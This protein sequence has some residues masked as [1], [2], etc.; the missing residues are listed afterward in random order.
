MPPAIKLLRPKQWIKNFF[1]FAPLMFSQHMFDAGSVI[2][3]VK[4]TAGLSNA[5]LLFLP[6]AALREIPIRVLN[7]DTAEHLAGETRVI[8]LSGYSLEGTIN[9][10]AV[11]FKDGCDDRANYGAKVRI[12]L[13]VRFRERSFQSYAE[14]ILL[15]PGT[16]A[17][18]LLLPPYQG[19]SLDSHVGSLEV[20]SRVLVDHPRQAQR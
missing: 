15:E 13:Y 12:A 16:R 10:R 14:E 11:S 1:V 20:Q 19:S 5:C 6:D 9:Q 7:D 2:A 3:S 17:L 18:V 4:L 8:N